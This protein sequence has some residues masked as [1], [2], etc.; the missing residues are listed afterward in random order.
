MAKIKICG[1][2]THADVAII[3][4]FKPD[5]IGFIMSPKFWRYVSP[6]QVKALGELADSSVKKVGVFV[7]QPV[8]EVA[9]ALSSGIIDL[10]QLHGAEDRAYEEAL[11]SRLQSS[12]I[13]NPEDRCIKAFRIRNAEDIAKTETTLCGKLLLDAYSE[14]A[15]GGTGE[16]FDWG[17][18]KHVKKP[19]FLAGGLNSENIS[20]AIRTVAPFAVD[21]SSSLETERRKDREKI[22]LFVSAARA[23]NHNSI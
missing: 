13:Q 10:A 5:Y 17:L 6:E 21:A 11:F 2:R 22:C 19:F 23:C 16:T 15:E 1:I 7:N 9:K 14:K 8:D 3:N 12:G 20:E 18:I 4:E